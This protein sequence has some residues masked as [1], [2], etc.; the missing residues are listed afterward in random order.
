[1]LHPLD[2][3]EVW[4]RYRPGA[5]ALLGGDFFDGLVDG[6]GRVRAMIGDVCGHG[7]AEA[8]LG[9]AL[10]IAWRTM[11]L[12][13]AEAPEVLATME[14]VL[15]RERDATDPFVTVCDVTIEPAAHR[16]TVRRH[17]HPPPLLVKPELRWVA[18]DRPAP[19]LGCLAEPVPAK[20]ITVDLPA[21]WELVL[22]TDGLLEGRSGDGR[23]GDE[24]L[25]ELIEKAEADDDTGS[26]AAVFDA[27]IVAAQ[28]LHGGD[29]DDDV[30]LLG[31]RG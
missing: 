6:E 20:P 5:D 4:T 1:V 29:L 26:T 31:L 21:S 17:G 10:R 12:A 19:P 8:A 11:V 16:M 22:L 3:V 7:P 14:Q 27:V 23:L 28:R 13:G 30:A 15:L 25:V 18:D 2:P 9:V 24:G